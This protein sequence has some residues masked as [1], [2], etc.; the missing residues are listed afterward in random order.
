MTRAEKKVYNA[1]HYA[2]NRERVAAYY[3][4]NREKRAA[5]AAAYYAKNREKFAAY[6][7][8]YYRRVTVP[9]QAADVAAAQKEARAPLV[10]FEGGAW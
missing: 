2:K 3:A 4:K 6:A 9:K 1:A 7:A 5:Y 8:A 10:A